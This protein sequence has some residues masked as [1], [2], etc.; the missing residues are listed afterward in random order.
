M[1]IIFH[2]RIISI[3]ILHQLMKERN[4]SKMI[5]EEIV[6][7]TM[8]RKEVSE[9]PLSLLTFSLKILKKDMTFC[10][11]LNLQEKK[12]VI[13]KKTQFN[14]HFLMISIFRKNK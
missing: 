6:E 12:S 13:A 10:K 1:I 8:P 2:K 9:L 11:Q 4:Q 7:E 3:D 5:V 14:T